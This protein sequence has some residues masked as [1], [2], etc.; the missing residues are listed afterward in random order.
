MAPTYLTIPI[1]TAMICL[2]AVVPPLTA[3]ARTDLLAAVLAGIAWIVL[4]VWI[5]RRTIN[6][7]GAFA[8][9][10]AIALAAPLVDGPL[11]RLLSI[12]ATTARLGL[13]LAGMAGM[14]VWAELAARRLE[15]GDP[16]AARRAGSA[17]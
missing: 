14:A 16:P 3:V 9:A 15:R 7:L 5:T 6:L 12:E 17:T 2:A 1:T 8:A 10:G 13:V 11:G 4:V